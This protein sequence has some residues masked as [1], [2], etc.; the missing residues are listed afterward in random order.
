VNGFSHFFGCTNRLDFS[1]LAKLRTNNQQAL[2]ILNDIDI[3]NEATNE[4]QT[5]GAFF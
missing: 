5:L 2:V 1:P 4:Q 3:M